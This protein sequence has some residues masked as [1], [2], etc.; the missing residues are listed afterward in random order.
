MEDWA[1]FAG[2]RIESF[3][4]NDYQLTT[5]LKG[6][7]GITDLNWN[8]FG[9]YGQTLFTNYEANNINL[10]ALENILYGTAN[11]QGSSGNNC[12]GYAWNPLG[13]QPLSKGC[14]EYVDRHGQEHQRDFAEVL[15][16]RSH[17]HGVE[18]P[19]GRP[20][21]RPGRRLPRPELYLPRRSR[22]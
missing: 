22:P 10:P 6:D 5:G 15:R 16:G 14:L 7:L 19:G 13:A 9:S 12:V 8:V 18:A 21:V 1:T 3:Q 11:Y 2:P 17:G 20:Q 4:Y